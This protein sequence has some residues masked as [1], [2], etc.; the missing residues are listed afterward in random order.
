MST[1]PQNCM[2]NK[3][4]RNMSE[5]NPPPPPAPTPP[6]SP[7]GLHTA[8]EGYEWTRILMAILRTGWKGLKK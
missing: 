3:G 7:Q 6:C 5:D 1:I 4:C 2:K 8:A